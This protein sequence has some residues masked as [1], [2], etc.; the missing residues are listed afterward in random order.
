VRWSQTLPG[1]AAK[2]VETR[3][4]LAGEAMRNGKTYDAPKRLEKRM[5]VE[6]TRRI[7]EGFSAHLTPKLTGAL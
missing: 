6:L 4:A 3:T 1:P 7:A 2:T 5:L